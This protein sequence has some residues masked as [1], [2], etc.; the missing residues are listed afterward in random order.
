M[1]YLRELVTTCYVETCGKHA[2]VEVYNT[3]NAS[4]G[5]C[6]RLHGKRRLADLQSVEADDS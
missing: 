2:V 6:C 5:R 4:C 1:A 3:Y